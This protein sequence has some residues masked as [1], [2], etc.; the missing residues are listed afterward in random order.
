MKWKGCGGRGVEGEEGVCGK[1][2]EGGVRRRGVGG[3]G[4][5]GGERRGRRGKGMRGDE[6]E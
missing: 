3:E 6:G 2:K 4:V 1:G 5:W